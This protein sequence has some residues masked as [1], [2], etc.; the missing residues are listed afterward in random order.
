MSDVTEERASEEAER[1]EQYVKAVHEAVIPKPEFSSIDNPAN[2]EGQT[3]DYGF[4]YELPERPDP[5]PIPNGWFSITASADLAAGEIKSVIAVGRE[6]VVLRTE[7]GVATVMDA[8]CPHLGAHLGGGWM[9]GEDIN[10]PYHGWKF[11]TDGTCVEIPYSDARIPSRACVPSYE[12]REQDGFVYFWYHTGGKA[13]Q[14]EIPRVSEADDPQWSAAHVWQF[15]MKA[16]LGEMAENNVDYAHLH[17]VHRR[18]NIPNDTSRFIPNGYFSEVVESLPE[19]PDFVRYTYGPGIALLRITD[20]MTIYATTTPIDR[21]HARLNWHF[22]FPRNVEHVAEEMIDGVTGEF[23]ILADIPIWRDKVYR[24]R[25]I[26]VKG[27]GNI[28]E[29]RQWYSQFYEDSNWD[30]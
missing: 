8:H 25:P 7:A 27:D 26:L 5:P 22:F 24:N 11:D 23:G 3:S 19:G 29:F 28:A 13:P 17:Y 1:A 30:G 6:L 2:T 4:T 14:Y 21:H 10:C 9:T 15:E 18:P 12:V 16:A 20:L